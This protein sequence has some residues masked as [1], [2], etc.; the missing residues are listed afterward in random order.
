MQQ[1]IISK[2]LRIFEQPEPIKTERIDLHKKDIQSDFQFCFNRI[3]ELE[4]EVADLKTP[5]GYKYGQIVKIENGTLYYLVNGK[6][7][8]A[9]ELSELLQNS[10]GEV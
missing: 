3:T 9:H 1:E 2:W 8:A 10:R 4:K 7:V 6:F 5:T